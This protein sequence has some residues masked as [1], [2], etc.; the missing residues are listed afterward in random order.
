MVDTLLTWEESRKHLP[1]M[2]PPSDVDIS[3]EDKEQLRSLGYIR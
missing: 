1:K 2:E 3:D